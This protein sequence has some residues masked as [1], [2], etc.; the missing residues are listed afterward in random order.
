MTPRPMPS[1]TRARFYP[2]ETRND[3]VSPAE[4]A[5]RLIATL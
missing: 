5:A 3:L 1:A 2:G 4:E